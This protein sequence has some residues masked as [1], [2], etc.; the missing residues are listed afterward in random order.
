MTHDEAL[1]ELAKIRTPI[2]Y[3]AV[4]K[5]DLRPRTEGLM[6]TSIRSVLPSLGPLVG[7]AVTGKVVGELPPVEGERIVEWKEMWEYVQSAPGPTVMVAQDMDQP[8]AQSCSWGDVAA[9]I[10]LR[11][12][13]V[14][15]ITNGGVRDL[16]EVEQLGFK[17]CA[18]N[19]VVGHA[20]IRWIEINTPVKVGGLVVY[21]GDLIHA[22]EHGVMTIPRELPL[23]QLVSFIHEFLAS[24]K[25]VV[26][27]CQ[28]TEKLDIDH[29]VQLMKEHGERTQ[30]HM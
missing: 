13:A 21:P 7:Y 29:V 27:Y 20:H 10:F 25:T 5:F 15:A 2:V 1:A 24:E 28:T 4:E 12:G 23:D 16:P 18:P 17:L 14:G 11:L 19:P 22:D 6:D 3:D 8:P 9:S 30:A 26:D